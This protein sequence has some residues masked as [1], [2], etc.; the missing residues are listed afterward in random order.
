[1]SQMETKNFC[2]H[3]Q[4]CNEKINFQGQFTYGFSSIA[5]SD[6]KNPTIIHLNEV[7]NEI[8]TKIKKFRKYTGNITIDFSDNY[9]RDAG[10]KELSDFLV[11]NP[12]ISSRL[13]ELNL[14]N[15]KFTVESAHYIKNILSSCPKIHIDISCSYMGRKEYEEEFAG[16][17]KEIKRITYSVW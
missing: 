7:L 12:D 9:I 1:M 14:R 15:N 10:I 17:N 3:C 6:V 8:N 11:E 16:A 4:H 5:D 2:K 13:T